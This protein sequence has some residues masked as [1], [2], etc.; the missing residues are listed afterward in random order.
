MST[1]QILEHAQQAHRDAELVPLPDDSTRKCFLRAKCQT[2]IRSRQP[3]R[4]GMVEALG[5]EVLP[6][7]VSPTK[8]CLGDATLEQREPRLNSVGAGFR[9]GVT[10]SAVVDR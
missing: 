9:V 7:S 6:K 1:Q 5:R 2:L 10:P 3:G 4:R 8:Q